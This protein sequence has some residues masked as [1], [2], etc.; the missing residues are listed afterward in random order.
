MDFFSRLVNLDSAG[1]DSDL[2]VVHSSHS[3]SPPFTKYNL[4]TSTPV[5]N[6]NFLCEVRGIATPFEDIQPLLKW[7]DPNYLITSLGG[8]RYYLTSQTLCSMV[9]D[10]INISALAETHEMES[11]YFNTNCKPNAQFIQRDSKLFL[12]ATDDLPLGTELFVS[13][14]L[15]YWRSMMTTFGFVTHPT[16]LPIPELPS[17]SIDSDHLNLF[18]AP[19]LL[20]GNIG[21]GIFARYNLPPNT[22]LCEYRGPTYHLD[23]PIVSTKWSSV[24]QVNN[25][26]WK[27]DGVGYC[28]IINDPSLI[29]AYSTTELEVFANQT[30]GQGLPLHQGFSQNVHRAVNGPKSFVVTSQ[31]IHAGAEL[32]YPYGV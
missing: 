2:L 14:G 1:F 29:R 18:S 9:N 15:D 13:R 3:S 16:N 5:P 11:D 8:Q 7:M 22:I 20:P 30:S 17:S 27:S 32:F 26:L 10:C 4:F 25:L 31:F 28:A 23:A 12:T 24:I 6:N 21:S 19:S